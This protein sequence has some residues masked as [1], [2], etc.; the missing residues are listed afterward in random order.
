MSE[1][2]KLQKYTQITHEQSVELVNS[3]RKWVNS[4]IVGQIYIYINI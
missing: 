3:Y 4:L 1:W 2:I